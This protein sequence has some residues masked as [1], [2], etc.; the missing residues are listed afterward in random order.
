[1]V[2]GAS[3]AAANLDNLKVAVFTDILS[4]PVRTWNGAEDTD[5]SGVLEL[6]L[7]GAQILNPS[8]VIIVVQDDSGEVAIGKATTS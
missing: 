8:E 3:V 1:V 6:D 7:T 4:A 2:D 5:G